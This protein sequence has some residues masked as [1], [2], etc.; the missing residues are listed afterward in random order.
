MLKGEI[1]NSKIIASLY[2]LESTKKRKKIEN[3]IQ[4]SL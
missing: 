3:L 2:A 1:A 4:L